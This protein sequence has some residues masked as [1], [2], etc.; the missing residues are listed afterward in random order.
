[1]GK[2]NVRTSDAISIDYENNIGTVAR[3]HGEKYYL[4][5]TDANLNLVKKN[6]SDCQQLLF[7]ED[8][9]DQ[10]IG[11]GGKHAM[12]LNCT[13]ARVLKGL[14]ERGH[15]RIMDYLKSKRKAPD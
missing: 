13:N 14:K 6:C 10:S 4:F 9:P 15:A 5:I 1:M 2:V 12:C 7:A 11:A 3:R 8:F